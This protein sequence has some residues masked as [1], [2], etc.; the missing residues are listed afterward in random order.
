M[1]QKNVNKDTPL[2]QG[3]QPDLKVEVAIIGA[4]TSGLYTAFRLVTDNKYKGHEVQIFDMSNRLGG[5]L[6]SVIMP[7]MNF[8]GELGGMRYLTSQE[9]VTTLIE[10]YPLKEDPS[11]RIPVLKDKMTPVLF[12]MGKPEELFMYIRKERFKQNAWTEKQDQGNK[13]ITRYFLNKNDE[14]LSSDQLFNKIIYNVLMSD[15]WVVENYKELIIED[16]NGYDYTFKLT[17]RDWDAI[18]PRMVY[19]FPGSPYDKRLVNDIGFWNL[20]KDQVS[21]EG[22]EFLANAGGYYS[23]TI[24]W[25]SAEAFPYM[26]GDFSAN[27]TYKTIEEGYDSIA[28]AIANAYMEYEG[29]RI[30]SENKLITF[31]KDHH[32][33][34]TH[35][36][37]LTFL[38]IQSNTTWKVYANS[39]V[40]GM[41][42]KSLELLDQNNFFFDANRH[43]KLNE[44]IRSI[45]MEPAFKILMGFERPW[46]KELGI[47]SGHSITDLPMRQCYY[48]GT[49]PENNNSMLLGSYGDMETETF[50]KALS[51]DKVLFKVRANKSTS[52]EELHKFDDVQATEFMVNELINQLKEV[53]GIDIPQP[54]ITYFRDW[55]DDPYGAGYHAWKAGFSVKD[56]MPYMRKPLID[57][58]IHII[59]EAY[60]DQQGWV[61]GAFCEAEKML[62]THYK[63]DWPY[64]LDPDYYLGW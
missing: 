7:G 46:W 3:M 64:W 17:S 25:N 10:G 48:F 1:N 11:K 52:M 41:P 59:G 57:E 2:Y 31:T 32:L 6:E 54:Y 62:Q 43:Q 29:T 51:D 55:T 63:L 26:V 50:W 47:D 24:N 60:S 27:T 16:P 53:H 37:E 33:I 38:N 20:I 18:K 12:P 34:S 44:N 28:Y 4:G 22:Y 56:V 23:N 58:Q 5:R 19:N 61:E 45:I 30:W 42:R 39:I 15:P 8:W 9:I 49:D 35:K 40:L 36:Y 14:G 13:L 21:Q